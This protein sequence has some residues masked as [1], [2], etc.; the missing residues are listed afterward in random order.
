MIRTD[1]SGHTKLT[2]LLGSPVEHSLSPLMHNTAFKELGLDYAYLCFD[3]GEAGLETAVAGL[4]MLGA[5]GFNL[6]MPDKNAIV[7]LCDRLSP[8]ARLIGAV[9]TV[10]N[11]RGTLTGHNTDGIGFWRSALDYGFHPQGRKCVLLGAGGAASAIAVQGALDGLSELKIFARFASRFHKRTLQII[12]GI[13]RE[14]ACRAE[15]VDLMDQ[16]A[17]RRAVS[18]A[19]IL[20]NATPVGMEPNTGHSLIPDIS[21]FHADLTV[22]DIIYHPRETLLLSQ[23]RQAGCNAFNGMDM[24][25]YQ[26][27]EAF[28]LWTGQ[29][30]PVDSIRKL[31]AISR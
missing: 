3:V 1:L 4:K 24:L 26:G 12:D 20:V 25:L 29:D 30:M 5:R 11:D 13:N 9:N 6:T 14:T 7:P 18:D 19:H 2:C 22:A 23:A 28:R 17:L 21:W 15:L 10:V 27:A 16:R 31:L 8:A